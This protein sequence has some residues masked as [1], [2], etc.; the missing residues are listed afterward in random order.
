MPKTT[1]P[2]LA[3][4]P[5]R[6]SDRIPRVLRRGRRSPGGLRCR[7]ALRLYARPCG[8]RP[9][10]RCR[11]CAGSDGASSQPPCLGTRLRLQAWKRGQD[12]D[13]MR[14]DQA[15]MRSRRL[16]GHGPVRSPG[17][18][19]RHVN[20]RTPWSII[21]AVRPP[22]PGVPET[23]TSKIAVVRVASRTGRGTHACFTAPLTEGKRGVLTA[24][25]R[26]MNHVRRLALRHGHLCLQHQVRAQMA[27]HRP[28]DDLATEGAQGTTER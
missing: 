25:I 6:A 3:L 10:P 19:D 22:R 20:A 13:G 1:T 12:C 9:R 26:M 27:C 17:R 4:E 14:R 21:A 11:S 24:L 18:G 5:S 15:P 8:Y 23:R 16:P 28:A 7:R 2:G